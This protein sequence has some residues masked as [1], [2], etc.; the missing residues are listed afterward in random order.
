[1]EVKKTLLYVSFIINLE[2]KKKE[3]LF[4]L[5]KQIPK[6]LSTVILSVKENIYGSK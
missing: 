4:L 3:L 6:I 1:M 2:K 5:K